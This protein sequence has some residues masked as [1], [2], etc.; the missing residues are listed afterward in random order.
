MRR[1]L[2]LFGREPS[3]GSVKS[4][5]AEAIGF[6]RAADVY[7]LLLEHA[8]AVARD[9]GLPWTLSLAE[10]P[11]ADWVGRLERTTWEV[12]VE[13]DLG[14]RLAQTFVRHLEDGVDQV[15]IVGSDC[16][17]VTVRHLR[18]SFRRLE[19]HRAVVGP[20]RDGGYWLIGQRRPAV[21]LFSGVPWSSPR[22]L[23]ATRQ[24]LGALGLSWAEL[25]TLADVDTAADL[26]SAIID[27]SL[28]VGLRRKLER[29]VHGRR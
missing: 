24:R 10:Q 17:G 23:D 9:S 7:A 8:L 27:V 26:A 14:R 28:P 6:E 11:S 5:L 13:G 19:A 16:P 2:V 20:A 21:D 3:P 1:R 18:R 25:E 15:V 29:A 12:Q 4:R 22:T